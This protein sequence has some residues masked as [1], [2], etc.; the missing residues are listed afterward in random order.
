MKVSLINYT[1]FGMYDPAD[2]AAKL[3]IYTK[4]T[5]LKQ[6]PETYA[7]IF[8]MP[9][10][11]IKDQLQYIANTI[12]SSWEFVDYTFQIEG[13]SRGFT[14]QFVR[15]RTGSFAQESQRTVSKEG[16]FGVVMPEVYKG[17]PMEEEW[18]MA[19]RYIADAYDRSIQEGF[20]PQ[21]ARAIL[22]TATSTNIIAKFN[23]RTMADM[24]PKRENIRAQG[25][26]AEVARLM[27][28]AMLK[29]HPW[30]EPFLW[31]DRTSTPALEEI[32]KGMVGTACP[33]ELPK[34]NDAL[35]ELDK[36]KSTWG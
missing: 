28:E 30:V 22:P 10:E 17:T 23:L 35:K 34:V 29:V 3:L 15:T 31:P 13:V 33:A 8:N 9:P 5:R 12:R 2:F 32:L 26:Y 18:H 36:L 7:E 4:S 16:G 21:D 1:G 11:V 27:G 19:I 24:I 6:S 20:S 25:E 14:H